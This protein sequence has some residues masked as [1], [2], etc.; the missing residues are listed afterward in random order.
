[1]AVP[2]QT[3]SLSETKFFLQQWPKMCAFI[4]VGTEKKK[5]YAISPE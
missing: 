5:R 4:R 3:R 1:M 2:N